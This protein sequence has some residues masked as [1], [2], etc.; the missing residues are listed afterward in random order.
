M[1]GSCM[2]PLNN[3]LVANRLPLKTNPGVSADFCFN[4]DKV[5]ARAR[6]GQLKTWPRSRLTTG[7]GTWVLWEDETS[8]DCA[9][10]FA[11]GAA[12]P[13]RLSQM[14]GGVALADGTALFP[15][16]WENMVRM[17]RILHLSD[18]A[19]T[20][21]PTTAGLDSPRTFSVGASFGLI[22]WPPVAWVISA[23]GASGGISIGTGHTA[24]DVEALVGASGDTASTSGID[25]IGGSTMDG[26]SHG[27][28]LENLKTGFHQRRIPW[29]LEVTV[30]PGAVRGEEGR[31]LADATAAASCIM[32]D[33]SGMHP[34]AVDQAAVS[35]WVKKHVPSKV[36]VAVR[37]RMRGLP[38]HFS[39]KAVTASLAE[40][41]PLVAAMKRL[42]ERIQQSRGRLFRAPEG[43]AFARA[44]KPGLKQG[45]P[46]R[47]GLA[48]LV[49]LAA[50]TGMPVSFVDVT[51]AGLC[52]GP[53]PD[54][55]VL[56]HVIADWA[57]LLKSL[58]TRVRVGI[59]PSVTPE[60]LDAINK[61]SHGS[62]GLMVTS[63]PLVSMGQALFDS[64]VRIEK[65][66]WRDWYRY[67]AESALAEA[68]GRPVD[69][70]HAARESIG[71]SLRRAYRMGDVFGSRTEARD[72]VDSLEPG[73]GS[74]LWVQFGPGF[75][76][77][78]GGPAKRSAQTRFLETE[79]VRARFHRISDSAG[80]GFSLRLARRLLGVAT[81]LRMAPDRKL[82][83]ASSA[84]ERFASSAE[85]IADISRF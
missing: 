31:V 20:V 25:C 12:A 68:F 63:A 40:S 80:L 39:P 37:A 83:I 85:F 7:E 76:T 34:R 70:R 69:S 18:G 28:V 52:P 71:E 1:M 74:P 11:D 60:S 21:F 49:A 33:F 67:S 72:A 79:S 55:S 53:H 27:I 5:V 46:D 47:C 14:A 65:E 78:H 32:Y 10:H 43:L 3:F 13:A 35:A 22:E 4:W 81:H 30:R 6:A 26:V 77:G 57:S 84:L 62:C 36:A 19:S 38:V 66:L 64:S 58:G 59:G 9:W 42:D 45:E 61:G 2:S 44:I 17:K 82:R 15:A 73:V 48:V 29:T 54:N 24:A 8:G 41:W 56:R 50:E 23:L 16:T 51:P 75:L